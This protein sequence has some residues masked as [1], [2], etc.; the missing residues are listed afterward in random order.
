MPRK[1]VV[2]VYHYAVM[3][4]SMRIF[5]ALSP[6]KVD[7]AYL[8]KASECAIKLDYAWLGKVSGGCAATRTGG[9]GY[10]LISISISP[11]PQKCLCLHLAGEF[12]NAFPVFWSEIV[13]PYVC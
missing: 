7:D 1:I 11:I 3:S 13:G 10:R 6:I 5:S 8:G 12:A 2:I 9:E 4:L